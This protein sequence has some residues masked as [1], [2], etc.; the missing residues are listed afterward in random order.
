MEKFGDRGIVI[1]LAAAVTRLLRGRFSWSSCC[2]GVDGTIPGVFLVG[3][4][5]ASLAISLSSFCLFDKLM[6]LETVCR[7]G[8]T[9]SNGFPNFG[10]GLALNGVERNA[11]WAEIA[12]GS[13]CDFLGRAME[14]LGDFGIVTFV[15]GRVPNVFFA[16]ILE[17]VAKFG[18]LGIVMR[19]CATGFFT[20]AFR[21]WLTGLTK[22]IR[23]ENL[24]DIG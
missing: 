3:V 22:G 1:F 18:S 2:F 15:S 14:K 20:A 24:G 11:V 17:A 16:S 19:G 6:S 23:F 13:I 21:G 5:K 12:S 9:G 4:C 7:C 8:R 10:A